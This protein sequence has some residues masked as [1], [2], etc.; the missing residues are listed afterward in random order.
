MCRICG[1][2]FTTWEEIDPREVRGYQSNKEQKTTDMFGEIEVK[3][4]A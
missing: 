2:R 3:A 4:K 1:H